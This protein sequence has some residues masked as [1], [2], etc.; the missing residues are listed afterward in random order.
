MV[1]HILYDLN[2][3]FFPITIGM[4]L[5]YLSFVCFVCNGTSLI[6]EIA[7]I[8]LGERKSEM[9][10]LFK[11]NEF[12]LNLFS[13][14]CHMSKL[15]CGNNIHVG[16][17][18]E[19]R[20]S[21]TSHNSPLDWDQRRNML[22]DVIKKHFFNPKGIER[23]NE[24][25]YSASSD[26]I[27]ELTSSTEYPNVGEF[28]ATQFLQLASLTGIAPLIC[29]TYARPTDVSLGSGN[30]IRLAL[31]KDKM[32]SMEC[33]NEFDNLMEDV[34]SVWDD[35]KINRAVVKNTL[36]ELGR[37]YWDTTCQ[38]IQD[39]N[40]NKPKVKA[41]TIKHWKIDKL[42]EVMIITDDR[43]RIESRAKDVYY[44][45]E[46]RDR[47]QYFFKLVYSGDGSTKNKPSLSMTMVDNDT[48][49]Q[50]LK[51]SIRL[52]NWKRDTNDKKMCCWEKRGT[53]MTLDTKLVTKKK[54][55]KYFEY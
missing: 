53:S 4:C 11:S 33:A 10:H 45:F 8:I 6:A 43:N 55:D 30:F 27:R 21:P 46:F 49:G 23:S 5:D 34:Q 51:K 39:D 40:K 15:I 24:R 16:S 41:K 20:H 26:F 50:G 9:I 48:S 14:L 47:I 52:T 12:S 17:C 22:M 44:H 42:P 7:R 37:S 3:N 1:L 13:F 29:Y 35:G 54:F 31:R 38:K 2:A 32:L 18:T 36:C 28:L 19:Q 25:L